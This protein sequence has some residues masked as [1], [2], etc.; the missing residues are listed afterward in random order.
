MTPSEKIDQAANLAADARRLA[1]EALAEGGDG[2]ERQ[3][4]VGIIV[5]ELDAIST[6]LQQFQA[7]FERVESTGKA[8]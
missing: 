7:D 3:T 6:R 8:A 5:G 1:N 4:V 2:T